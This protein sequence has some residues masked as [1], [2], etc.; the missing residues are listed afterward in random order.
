MR[1]WTLQP[2]TVWDRLQV[3]HEIWSSPESTESFPDFRDDYDWMREAMRQ[4]VPNYQG[5]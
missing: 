4:R 1:L 5:H 3:E 2:A